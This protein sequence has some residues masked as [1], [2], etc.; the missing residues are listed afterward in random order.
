MSHKEKVPYRLKAP[1]LVTIR[2]ND[3]PEME[4]AT[5]ENVNEQSA[6]ENDIPE[7]KKYFWG[8]KKNYRG[9]MARREEELQRKVTRWQEALRVD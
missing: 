3:K 4:P 7:F 2:D 8:Q 5:V 9:R 6:E 1:N